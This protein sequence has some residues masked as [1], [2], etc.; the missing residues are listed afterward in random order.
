MNYKDDCV[1]LYDIGDKLFRIGKNGIEEITIIEID[2]YPHYVYR[3]DRGHSYFNHNI[4][5]SCFKTEKE[6]KEE[7]YR[8]LRVAE[9]RQK[10]KE[11][12]RLLNEELRL[13]GHFIV[14]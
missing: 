9:K 3:D 7:V 10:L 1:K 11:Y 5:K 2:Q 13:E 8:R 6:A 12:E 14:K 4:V